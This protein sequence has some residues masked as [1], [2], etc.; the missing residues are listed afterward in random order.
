MRRK[1]REDTYA[2]ADDGWIGS[3]VQSFLDPCFFSS[4]MLYN[5]FFRDK[6]V[7]QLGTDRE[8]DGIYS[9]L[10]DRGLDACKCKRWLPAGPAILLLYLYQFSFMY[11]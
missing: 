5:I 4:D 6:S 3:V 2:A 1:E 8:T 9:I 10:L 7:I 11:D